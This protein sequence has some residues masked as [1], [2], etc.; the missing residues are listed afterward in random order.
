MSNK[1]LPCIEK[2]D[3]F[4]YF[5]HYNVKVHYFPVRDE[6]AQHK[7][8]EESDRERGQD[9]FGHLHVQVPDSPHSIAGHPEGVVAASVLEGR[10]VQYEL[11][12]GNYKSTYH[13]GGERG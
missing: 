5:S 6:H 13:K 8:D 9:W 12:K 4:V 10:G 2:V 11:K 1:E 3:L 7:V